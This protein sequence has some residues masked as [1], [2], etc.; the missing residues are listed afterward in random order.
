[1]R[2][3]YR[4]IFCVLFL[5]WISIG[6]S[7]QITTDDTL[8]IGALIQENLGQGCVEISNIS[9][10]V[11]GLQS[12][13][14]SFGSFQKNGSDFPFQDGIILSTGSI[15][16]AG[17]ALNTNVL[18]EGDT[19][20][21]PDPDLE[22]ALDI[23]GT[24]NATSIEFD[25]TSVANQVQ[26]NYLLASEEYSGTN[27]CSYSDGFAF[28]IKRAGTF[29][30]YTNI[31]L[32][33]DTDTPVN[34]NT[35]HDEITGFCTASNVSYF[36]GYN[37]GDTNYNGR[38]TVLTAFASI[39]P[40]VAYHIKLVIAD[41][42]DTFYDSAVFIE[43]NSFNA[44]VNL[45]QDIVTCANS[46]TLNG[47]IQNSFASYTWYLDGRIIEG[48]TNPTL[49]ATATGSYS[50]EISIELNETS[51]II[52]DVVEVTLN[53]ADTLSVI[54][55]YVLCDDASGDGI[56]TFNLNSKKNEVLS[57]LP[58]SNYN[59]TFH[60]SLAD[61]QK[62][63]DP[64][65]TNYKNNTSP[66]SIFVRTEDTLNGCITFTSFNLIVNLPPVAQQPV[67]IIT[68]DN[69]EA[70]GFTLIDLNPTT[71]EVT[72]GAS[73]LYVSY[74]Y[75]PQ[76]ADSGDNAVFSPYSNINPNETL[77]IRVFDPITGCSSTTSV[78][79]TVQ[80][81][82]MVD[83][84]ENQWLSACEMSGDGFADFDLTPVI[85]DLLNGLIGVSVTFHEN[86]LDAQTGDNPIADTTNYQ[87]VV[88][89]LQIIYIRVVDD[90]SG[91][92]TIL[93][94]ELH[95][96]ITETGVGLDAHY[97]CDDISNDGI[98]EFD[99]KI[100]AEDLIGV[101]DELTV[102]FYRTLEDFN[103]NQNPLNQNIPFEVDTQ[104][105]LFAQIEGSDCTEM[106]TVVLIVTPPINIQGLA[107]V[108][109]CDED[110]D[111]FTSIY[112]EGLNSTITAG[113]NGATVNYYL[114]EADAMHEEN[115]LPPYFYNLSNP[116]PLWVRVDSS[117]TGCF[118][119]T[120]ININV[121]SAP[122]ATFPTDI[123][124]CDD[125]ADGV[126]T[127]NLENKIPEIVADTTN[128]DISFYTDYNNA[129]DAVNPIEN[130]NSYASISQLIM[131]RLEDKTTGCYTVVWFYAYINTIHEFIPITTF[132]NCEADVSAMADF[133]FY[134]KDA[135][136]LNGGANKETLYF[137]TEEDAI[138][139][140]NI[141]DKYVPYQN[142]SSPQTM[143][144]RVEAT[145]DP[146]CYS[147]SKFDLEIGSLPLFNPP[148]SIFVCD[149]NSND[150]IDTFDLTEKIAEISEGIN[151]NLDIS[152]HPSQLDAE[153]NQNELPLQF[154]NYSNPQEVF[155]RVNNGTYCNA[156]AAFNIN[157]IQV[158]TVGTPSDLVMC[159][160]DYDGAVN[161]DI[162]QVEVEILD[163]R[164]NSIVVTYH[165]SYEGSET[166]TEII[167]DP[168]SYT[169]TSNP[170]TVYVK[171]NNTISDCYVA[172]PVNLVVDLPPAI[173]DFRNFEICE[174]P[175]N[176]FDLKT[177][178]NVVSNNPSEVNISYHKSQSD[179]ET[180]FDSI[181]TDYNY[182]TNTDKIFIR[183][184]N[185]I[186]GCWTTYDFNLIVNPLPIANSPKSFLACDDASNDGKVLIDLALQNSQ[187]LGT[188][189][190]DDHSITYHPNET[191]ANYGTNAFAL[192]HEA[193]NGDII[194][195]RIEN[196]RTGCYAV[197]Q[198]DVFIYGHPDPTLPI[199]NCDADFDGK[200]SFDLTQS[201]TDLYKSPPTYIEISYFET[202]TDLENEKNEIVNFTDYQ[203]KTNPQTVYIK[204]YNNLADCYAIVPLKLMVNLPPAINQL[205]TYDI[206]ANPDNAFDLNNIEDVLVDNKN[207]VLFSY[208]SNRTDALNSDN[209]LGTNYKYQ[210]TNDTIFVRVEFG[211]TTCF[212]VYEFKLRV[213]T[214]PIA[215]PPE[216][217]QT[218]DDDYDGFFNF[219]L[220]Q[221]NAT[222][223][224]NQNPNDFTVS[225]YFSLED[226]K[227]DTGALPENFD[228]LNMDTI[229]VRV[230]NNATG[231]FAL[232][233]FLTIVN[234]KP[235]VAI[236]DQIL[237]L[238]NLPLLVSANTNNPNDVYFW[239]TN[240]TTTE[241][242]ISKI[243]TYSVTITS[244]YGCQTTSS[245]NVTESE[246]ATIEVTETVD[247][248]DPN[249]I[250]VTI[251]GIGNYLYQ[252]DDNPMQQSN[253]FTNV[254]LGYHTVTVID[255]NGCAEVTKEVVVIDAPKFITP[256]GD[257][258]FD[259]W[260]ITG[261]ETLV[262]SIV[263]IYDRYGKLL[264][265]LSHTSQGWDG[266]YQG[267]VMPATDYWYV[268]QIRK[269]D[270]AFEVKG[271]FSLRL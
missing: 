252:L 57:L 110:T 268:A 73:N 108:D 100:V 150:A 131:V 166:D 52:S 84:I 76:D 24:V 267:R 101:Y 174:N 262:G 21:G 160:T 74:H 194:F 112:L 250:T 225:Y 190:E 2:D 149:D 204:A 217:L 244:E 102:T 99:L 205:D 7:Q 203:N 260:H 121:V 270:I 38:T 239:S 134:L 6:Q 92:F 119:I 162:S 256:N 54:S 125:D 170:Q 189:N 70:D 269:G 147:T 120:Q 210:N 28:L 258:H 113:I 137:E 211:A 48:E 241:I 261:V 234:L 221:Q 46:V 13:F 143:Y 215:N 193:T 191:S 236:P 237:C 107:D 195:V 135:E 202:V 55:D 177:I 167:A 245:F 51:C 75:T 35:I 136:I 129:Y 124:I 184:E 140:I 146:T 161:F 230:E 18:G 72:G 141:I 69:G 200:T 49:N 10:K 93:P 9:T 115:T 59:V 94:L 212:Y 229:F 128:L 106:I 263:Y 265:T 165:E 231:C 32:L 25:F 182:T 122:V 224:G 83:S 181:S 60:L 105:T 180:A 259:T 153:F 251:R 246:Q 155:A 14:E 8:P 185:P 173:N 214:L 243:G 40:N 33:P 257:G 23:T 208:Y 56:E 151:Q 154:T 196:N 216:D 89:G 30:P 123:I 139:R 188:Q 183:I 175:S 64:L 144:V 17:N 164:Q 91:C 26:F 5:G 58:P 264:K 220:T 87:N 247:F 157:I 27:P 68:C 11:N 1:M 187:V 198:F 138:D 88:P 179:A 103:T 109:Y 50:V 213:N 36:E 222:V 63:N 219:D 176:S 22:N 15:A 114:T 145:N 133:Y 199:I 163:V 34:T 254:A 201:K 235:Y 44:S 37:V 66:Q 171:I 126:F 233:E 240:E 97:A 31:A 227:L 77:Y 47:D 142:T 148:T 98:A 178:N 255:L 118:D 232:T 172:L 67:P 116:Q 117:V 53:S 238:E 271:H 43:S 168:T 169:N 209:A 156:I 130:P 197:T 226:A 78:D 45:G 158:P 39:Q 152:F 3:F 111:G 248:S 62:G 127:L 71:N 253:V 42:A 19:K 86:D 206:C 20:W 61:A 79:I 85:A 41:Q 207:D 159:D 90:V 266:T 16:S 192:N 249:N 29:N 186:K 95:T 80:K 242:E 12:G 228:A 82:P 65:P 4:E 81:S 104:T 96:S 132:K 223:L 218:C